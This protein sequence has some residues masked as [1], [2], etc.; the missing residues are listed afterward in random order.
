MFMVSKLKP[1][2][3]PLAHSASALS[4]ALTPATAPIT[5]RPKV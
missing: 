1:S 3:T 2:S 5:G 4:L